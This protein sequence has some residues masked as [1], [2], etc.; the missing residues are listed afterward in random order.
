V[1]HGCDK[2]RLRLVRLLRGGTLLAQ[3]GKLALQSL[4]AAGACI[5]SGRRERVW[6]IS[7]ISRHGSPSLQA[8][9]LGFGQDFLMLR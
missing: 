8:G 2:Q 9:K 1:T 4:E 6:C 7:A 5:A 3:D